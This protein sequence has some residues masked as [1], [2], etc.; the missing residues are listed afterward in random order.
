MEFRPARS[1]EA[2]NICDVLRRSISALCGLDHENN[3]ELLLPWLANKTPENVR[4]WIEAPGQLL[5]VALIG[6]KLAGVGLVTAKGEIQLNYVSPDFRFRG[7]SKGMMRY[8]EAY[9]IEH[10]VTAASLA[11]TETAREFYKSLG[12]VASEPQPWRGGKF[13]YPMRKEL[14]L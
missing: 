4:K 14:N 11:S 8:L 5:A 1:D 7:V 3:D 13:S 10:G 12:Y 2:E 9:L 6:G